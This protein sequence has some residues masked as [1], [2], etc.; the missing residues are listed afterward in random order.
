MGRE[1]TFPCGDGRFVRLV[2]DDGLDQ[3]EWLL[4]DGADPHR[5]TTLGTLAA[6]A[7]V[8]AA[9][10][11]PLLWVALMCTDASSGTSP[12]GLHGDGEFAAATEWLLERPAAA[13]EQE[14][15]DAML[16]AVRWLLEQSR[17]G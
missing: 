11:R 13:G 6:A 8:S 1:L 4:V 12:A 16:S 2:D 14:E 15:Q 3:A 17:P 7:A 5:S 9:Y 10:R